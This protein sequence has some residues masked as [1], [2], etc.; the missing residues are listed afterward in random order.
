MEKGDYDKGML[1]LL[2]ELTV[3]GDV[4]KAKFEAQFDVH[5]SR[6]DDYVV[7]VIEDETSSR[8]LA[9][10]TL[11]IEHKFIRSCSKV[12]HI[13]DVVVSDAARGQGL[14]RR[15]VCALMDAGKS[16]G[17]YKVILDCSDDNVPFYEKVGL[18][19][20]EVQMVKYFI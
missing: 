2:G 11:L 18:S 4:D 14:G 10:G 20:K 13:E 15:I 7:L 6:G 3:V 19:R 17:C 1:E 8:I 9:T 16:L 12:G 5:A